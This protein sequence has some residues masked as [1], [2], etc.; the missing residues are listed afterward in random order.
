MD[1]HIHAQNTPYI[2]EQGPWSELAVGGV[3]KTGGDTSGVKFPVKIISEGET[4]DIHCKGQ[5]RLC[6]PEE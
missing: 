5:G 3:R 1:P 4:K 2:G 6:V